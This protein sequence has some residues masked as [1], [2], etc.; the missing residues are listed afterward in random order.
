[1]N[2]TEQ[3]AL[4]NTISPGSYVKDKRIKRKHKHNGP[5]LL[6]LLPILT[7]YAVFYVYAFYF[8]IQTSFQD[9]TLSFRNAKPVGFQNYSLVL[10]HNLF[11]SAL[12]NPFFFSVLLILS[13]L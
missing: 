9:V 8:L 6:F 2:L 5:A 13:I 1:M 12:L 3:A 4:Q 10:P 7:F 11:F